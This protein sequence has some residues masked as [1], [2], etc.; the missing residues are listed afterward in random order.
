MNDANRS[1]LSPNATR[2][3]GLLV[4]TACGDSLGLPAEGLSRQRLHRMMRS[5]WR[6]QLVFGRGMISDDTE[7]ALFVAQCLLRSPTDSTNFARRLGWCLRGWLLGLPAG[8]GFATLRAICKLWLGFSPNYSGVNSAGNGPAMRVAIIGAFF[9]D[10]RERRLAYVTAS[11]RVTH[12]DPKALAGATAIAELAA[13]IVRD[14]LEQRPAL[15]AFIEL[16]R[17]CGSRD[18][19]WLAIVDKIERA[20]RSGSTVA[21]L[22]DRL[23]LSKGATGYIYH[24]VPIVAYAWFRHFGDFRTA[25]I[26]VLDCGGDTDT[27]GAIVGALAGAVV[28]EAGI[29]L[30]WREGV[31]D[32]PRSLSL[33]RALAQRLS[34]AA[35][36]RQPLAPVRYFWLAIPLRNL[37]FLLIVLIH[38]FRRLLPPY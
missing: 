33:L 7:H 36:A 10:D 34:L 18:Q 12:T 26:E 11:T 14:H 8:I 28:G 16:L 19:E 2:F 4:G 13:W 38:G 5:S 17:S 6:H 24:T 22:A 25:L 29:P 37:V 35:S 30:D 32:W 27:T 15:S 21:V 9:A 23:G 3:E 1:D 20:A 31:I